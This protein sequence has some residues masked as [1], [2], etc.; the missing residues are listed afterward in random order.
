MS[1]A[2]SFAHFVNEPTCEPL[3]NQMI[4]KVQSVREEAKL[5]TLFSWL[6]AGG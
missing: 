2:I 1:Q 3:T 4:Y 5:S 6:V